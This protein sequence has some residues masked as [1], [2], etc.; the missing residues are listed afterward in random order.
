MSKVKVTF[1]CQ[2]CGYASPK[3]L[4]KCPDCGAWNSFSEESRTPKNL[5]SAGG[6]APVVLSDVSI[7]EG[8]RY[9]TAM[10]ELDRVLGGGLVPGS[11][12]LVG[13]DPGIGKSTLLL[14]AVAG[15]AG[16]L[17]GTVLYVSA[18][19]SLE[20][21]KMRA[22]R[23]DI[24]SERIALL[25][26]TALEVILSWVGKMKP[27]AL[28]VD[29]I[30]TIFTDTLPSAP[31]SVGQIREC[32]G[33][34]M[35]YAKKTGMPVFIIGHV[36]KEGALAGPRVLEHIV[37]TVLY[38]EGDRGHSYRILR[39]VKNRF[40]STNEIGVFEMAGAGLKEVVNPSALF[41]SERYQDTAGS[42]VTAAVE[43]T[44]PVLVEIQALVSPTSF[45]MPRRT[46]IGIDLN[47]VNLLIAVCEKVGA[48]PLG[49]MD[50]FVN[51]VGG[52]RIAEPS[53]DLCVLMTVVSSLREKN[54]R[55]DMVVFGEVGLT[56]EVRSVSNGE[57]R[58]REAQK[59][60]FRRVLVPRGNVGDD[61]GVSGIELIAV[62]DIHEAI[63]AVF[64]QDL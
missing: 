61:L 49:A 52:L 22:D 28:V 4:G 6:S 15:L 38:F 42:S 60:G 44:R 53:A 2:A 55:N 21:I 17:K 59:I 58:I 40:G 3:W 36:T 13:G 1:Q 51:V 45:G 9:S 48:I 7:D 34:L 19:E 63:E 29:S 31:G 37:D 35:S 30:Q 39:A 12:V 46:A 57:M 62:K 50:V 64:V 27:T 25:S 56:G 10:T 8:F 14:Q 11:V 20:Q 32:S 5:S 18:E 47:R 54:I 33:T 24:R 16:T 26:E 41:L 43:G 23:L